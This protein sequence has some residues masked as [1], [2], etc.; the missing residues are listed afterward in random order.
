MQEP[1]NQSISTTAH[2]LIHR[3]K[4]LGANSNWKFEKKLKHHDQCLVSYMRIA[5][6]LAI[7]SVVEDI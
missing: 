4:E 7:K 6:R 3:L 5:E 2:S 1:S